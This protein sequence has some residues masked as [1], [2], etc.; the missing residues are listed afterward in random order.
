MKTSQTT[1]LPERISSIDVMRGILILAM[2]LVNDIAGV[3]GTPYWM[4]H[5]P[6]GVD[7][8]TFADLV[9]PGFL[10]L[11]GMAIPLSIGRKLDKGKTV[12]ELLPQIG[13]R[14][15]SLII[16]GLFMVNT[17]YASQSGIVSKDLWRFIMYIAVFL[18]WNTS[19]LITGKTKTYLQWLGACVL[20]ILALI[21]RGH[22]VETAFQ[23]RV[24]WWGILALIGWSYLISSIVYIYMRKYPSAIMLVMF[25]LYGLFYACVSG[26]FPFV[27]KYLAWAKIGPFF[28]T[29]TSMVIAGIP[30]GMILCNDN[31]IAQPGK[32]VKYAF[33]YGFGLFFMGF[34][35]H[36]MSNLNEMFWVNKELGTPTWG[37]YSTA[38]TAWL[39]ALLYWI[40]DIRK[41]DFWIKPLLPA[42]SNALFVYILTPFTVAL[43]GV[44][45]QS[46]GFDFYH[47]L[48][49]NFWLGLT[50]T[51]LLMI[52]IVWLVAYF[53]KKGF[54]LKL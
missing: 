35:I 30:L 40:I 31:F 3:T 19:S 32:R 18:I 23:M 45:G 38:I 27:D 1:N 7:G 28:G 42:G 52:G 37:L 51:T 25:L 53:R 22:N 54:N 5:V 16:I 8:M 43:L 39:W 10:F 34:F 9:F 12:R 41:W 14:S 33:F 20:I 49:N 4:K 11:V 21:Y 50:R 46:F 47:Y 6:L 29:N 36:K 48:S 24:S 26:A 2:I 13:I 15:I 44:I 17:Y